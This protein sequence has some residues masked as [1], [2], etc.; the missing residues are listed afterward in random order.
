M[1][2]KIALI[3]VGLII[4]VIGGKMLWSSIKTTAVGQ[5]IAAGDNAIAGFI[6]A[7]RAASSHITDPAELAKINSDVAELEATRGRLAT[8]VK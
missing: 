2:V 5:G 4:L 8:Q 3:G 6:R 1:G 7:K